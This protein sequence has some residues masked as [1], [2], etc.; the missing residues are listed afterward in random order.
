MKNIIFLFAVTGLLAAVAPHGHDGVMNIGETAPNS[1]VAM[2][3]VS[4]DEF[5]LN[6]L[7]GENG[8]LVV[9]SCNTC[10]FVV[11]NGDKSEGWEGRYNQ[12]YELAQAEGIGMVLVNSNAAKR[13]GDDSFDAMKTHAE[14]AGYLM[15]YVVDEN[16]ALADAFGARTT[17][18]VFLFD[19]DMK[20]TYKGAVDD[21]VN[22]S[23]EVEA[24]Y[25]QD[26]LSNMAAGEPI[27]PNDTK[28]LGCS[29]KRVKTE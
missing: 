12:L 29:I 25:L 22:S 15:N 23:D 11:G 8:L 3:D 26:A 1:D 18:H 7:K 10:P 9:F 16:S 6:D 17:P 5:S 21:N 4:G 13:D 24:T 27:D 14:E 28:E 2:L 19:A 20:L